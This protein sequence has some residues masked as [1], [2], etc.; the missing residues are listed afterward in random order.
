[1]GLWDGLPGGAKGQEQ[2]VRAPAFREVLGSP[3]ASS[4]APGVK[5]TSESLGRV[6][7]GSCGL[8]QRPF[9]GYLAGPTDG[10]TGTQAFHPV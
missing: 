8:G 10:R 6:G 2:L 7:L 3:P 4:L 1:M 5:G 9:G